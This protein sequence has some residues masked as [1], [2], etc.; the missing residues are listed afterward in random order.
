MSKP[1]KIEVEDF[2]A[3]I[4]DGIITLSNAIKNTPLT[5]RAMIVLLVD[6][7]GLTIRDCKTVIRA[8]PQLALLYTDQV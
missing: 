3:S 5:E 4:A 1:V 7:T 6:A 2:G 8:I